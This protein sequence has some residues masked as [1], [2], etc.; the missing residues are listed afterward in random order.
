MAAHGPAIGEEEP[1]QTVTVTG[2]ASEQIVEVVG[3]KEKKDPWSDL[4]NSLVNVAEPRAREPSGE[5]GGNG[6][7]AGPASDAN[8]NEKKPKEQDKPKPGKCSGDAS[9]PTTSNPVIIATG[10]KYLQQFDFGANS[11][12]GIGLSRTYRSKSTTSTFFGANWASSV[13]FPSATMSGCVPVGPKG[14]QECGGP[15]SIAVTF[16]GGS[17]YVYRRVGNT[18]TYSVAGSKAMG[19][20]L[21]QDNA[22]TTFKLTIGKQVIAFLGNSIQ[23]VKTLGGAT[24]LTYTYGSNPTQPTRITNIAGQHIDFTW[25]NNRVTAVTDPAGGVW[26]YTYNAN[27]MLTTVTSPGANPDIRTYLY[28]DPAGATRL[29]G[30]LIN[31]VRYSTYRYYADGRVQESGLTGG[32]QKDTFVYGTN[33]TTVT[34]AVGQAV[35]YNFAA[36]QGALKLVSTSRNATPT[37]PSA[38]ASTVYDTNGWVDYTLDWNGN[39]T[40]YTYDAAGKLLDVTTAAGTASALKKV[41]TWSGDDLVTTTYFNSTGVAYA[42]VDYTYVAT[43]LPMGKLASETWTDLRLGG[44]R[45][46]TY[47]YS[48]S[49][50]NV[51]SAMVATQA[52]PGGA[53]NVTTTNYDTL[54]NVASVTNGLG[55]SRSWSNYNGF[56]QPGR[57]TDA[58][59]VITDYTYDAKG[60]LVSQLLYHPSGNRVTTYAY[61]NN[62]QVTDVT[63]PTGRI[64]RSRYNAATRLTQ[65]GNALNEYVSFDYDVATNTWRTRSN[66]NVPGWNG[67]VP[68]ATAAGEF[69]ATTQMDSLGRVRVQSGNNGQQVTFT[70]DNN[71]NVKTRTDAAGRVTSFDYDAQNRLVRTVAPDGGVTT[72]S[73][74]SEGN[75]WTVTDP[76]GLITRYTYN[77][78]GQVLSRQSPDT[79]STTYTYDTAGR[80]ATETRANGVV[81]SYGWD[82][83]GRPT[84]RTA[85]G[86]TETTTYDE[87][88][89]GRGRLTRVNDATG[90]TTYQY[91]PAGALLNQT[92]T[93][94]G[95]A[96]VVSRSYDAAGRLIDLT[97]PNGMVLRHSWDGNE[98]L[99]GQSAYISGV[100][101][102][103]ADAF[104][105]QPATERLYAWR[106]GNGSGRLLT[107]D[108]DGRLTQLVSGPQS[109]A[110]AY[111][112][113]NTIAS[114]TD[115]TYPSLS[116]AFTY[117]SSDRLSAVSRSGDSQAFGWDAVG[118][119]T[120]HTRAGASYTYTYLSQGN[121]L[122]AVTGGVS[123]NI[124][125][126]AVGN[127]AAESGTGGNRSY[128]YD[129][130]NRLGGFY[131]NGA[132]VG[133]YRSNGLNQRAYKIA[134][135]AG[136]RYIYGTGGELVY[137]DGP[138]STG[139][140]WLG[141]RLIGVVRAGAM[142]LAHNDHLGRPVMLANASGAITWRASNAAFD[143]S[144]VTDSIGGLNLGFPGQYIDAESGLWYNWNR[145]YD[146]ATGRYVQSDPIGLA[147]GI[148][149]YAYV[150]ANPISF[151]DPYGL[152]CISKQVKDVASA[153]AGG[154]AQGAVMG[155]GTGIGAPLAAIA[156]G[157]AS[158][159]AT[160][161]AGVAGGAGLAGAA[162]GYAVGGASG[163]RA[164]VA[165]AVSGVLGT[166][167]GG[168]VGVGAVAGALGGFVANAPNLTSPA[169]AV[170]AMA[171]GLKSGGLGALA[172]TLTGAAIDGIN[173]GFGDCGCGK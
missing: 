45:Q 14:S 54:G 10:E 162:A 149:T 134:A 111:S 89:Y 109:L 57:F 103:V 170:G 43:G 27:G 22:T 137:E 18:W 114:I 25:V 17:R 21:Y 73:Y 91:D 53:T 122:S 157:V 141:G 44:T 105:Y 104:L 161:Y 68:T 135:G 56:G 158:G 124:S 116:S 31:G 80:L 108:T 63:Y 144:V 29:T 83:L 106:F 173:A 133:D 61:N 82:A 127:F 87:G 148:N 23:S 113:T 13:D 139:Y 107:F 102:A 123:R 156:N 100:W 65:Q 2:S 71:G 24:L 58:N 51:L 39:K 96:Y 128:W 19:T 70:Y 154:A 86:V 9:N 15:T 168:T 67:S 112:N 74:D 12:Y 1:I 7:T 171:N 59:G 115:A 33:S 28:E 95:V 165:G 62:R 167:N 78:F 126:D 93:I 76:R 84:S 151:V 169:A 117:D 8:T 155:A 49:A 99:A 50:S 92:S 90:Q 32:E 153:V 172:S 101:R 79:G 140:I 110:Y 16:P 77:G 145:Y 130:F 5:G 121:Q 118:N 166:L 150:G 75:L 164:L 55:H 97:Y 163:S 132:L 98:R 131:L 30:M 146:A 36:V 147:G 152:F 4:A 26:A 40:D 138:Q 69:L 47:A 34:S 72:Q 42:K 88:T 35:T 160:Y 52:L 20:V 129:A 125:Y 48:Y 37:C 11:E 136:T 85:G 120:S 46:T 6:N 94:Y 66:R 38:V 81:V 142:H 64:D 119:R 159:V 60:N 3:T 41:N 143:R